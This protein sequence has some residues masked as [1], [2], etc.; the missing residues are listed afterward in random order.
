MLMASA[1]DTICSGPGQPVFLQVQMPEGAAVL[2]VNQ[3]K[4]ASEP[5]KKNN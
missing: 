3:I 4:T 2:K 1:E 5:F